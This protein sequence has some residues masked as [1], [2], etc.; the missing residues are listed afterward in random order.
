MDALRNKLILLLILL[1]PNLLAMEVGAPECST[2]GGV[3]ESQALYFVDSQL[4]SS[5][6]STLLNSDVETQSPTWIRVSYSDSEIHFENK[7][8]GYGLPF[9]IYHLKA[10]WV[11]SDN[12]ILEN[13][14]ASFPDEFRCEGMSLFP[15][16]VSRKIEIPR[17]QSSENLRLRVRVWTSLF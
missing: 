4:D 16:Q 12:Q 5:V 15:S 11:N 3:S 13:E 14:G 6:Q 10:D 8:P 2:W 9:T 17:P 7:M 1:S